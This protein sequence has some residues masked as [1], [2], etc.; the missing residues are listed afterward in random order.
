MSQP[1]RR[2]PAPVLI[3]QVID[4]NLAMLISKVD[5]NIGHTD[6][7]KVQEPAQTYSH[8]SSVQMS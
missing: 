2:T 6:T 8:I 1:V 3:G 7:I 5:V 4:D